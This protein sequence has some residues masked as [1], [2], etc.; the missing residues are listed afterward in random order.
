M[1]KSMTAF[2]RN[3]GTFLDNALTIEAKSLNNRYLDTIVHVPKKYSSL[4]DRFKKAVAEKFSRG[5]VEILVRVEGENTVAGSIQADIPLARA[6]CRVLSEVERELGLS[7]GISLSLVTSFKDVVVVKEAE[8]DLESAWSAVKNVLGSVLDKLEQMRIEEGRVLTAD[9][10]KRLDLLS[11]LVND[12]RNHVSQ[13]ATNSYNK[14]KQRIF[15]L[16]GDVEVDTTRIAQEVALLVDRS[17]ITEELV[18]TESHI[19]QFRAIIETGGPA[20][21]KLD[22]L[23]QEMYREANTIGSKAADAFVSHKVVDMK[24]ELE[25]IREQVQNIE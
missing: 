4:E 15:D 7:G 19:S 16:A 21:R 3:S 24:C 12:V 20:G 18:R 5:R 8:P 14:L 6:Y 11:S 23:I 9:L 22:F 1:L 17:D 2:G 13:T 10:V 25:K